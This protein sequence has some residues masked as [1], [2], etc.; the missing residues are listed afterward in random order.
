MFHSILTLIQKL[1]AIKNLN[2]WEIK[3]NVLYLKW[4]TSGDM[5]S[6]I[7]EKNYQIT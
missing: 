3:P 4:S 2:N 6:E 1:K 7:L 5:I